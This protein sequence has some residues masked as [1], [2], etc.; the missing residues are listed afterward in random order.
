MMTNEELTALFENYRTKGHDESFN[1]LEGVIT[2]WLFNLINS[3]LNNEDD[4]KDLTQ[5]VWEDVINKRNDFNPEIAGLKVWIYQRIA[6]GKILHYYRDNTA[7]AIPYSSIT[8]KN[9][10]GEEEID[11]FDSLESPSP[12]PVDILTVKNRADIIR[13][14]FRKINPNYQDVF[15]LKNY[16]QT[17]LFDIAEIMNRDYA[18]IRTWHRNAKAAI[19]KLIKGILYEF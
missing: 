12:T 6:R 17:P 16:G 8:I 9:E 14:V 2:P 15:I 11:F 19:E 10:D 3:N 5:M 7:H 18:T 4:A 1:K 13:K